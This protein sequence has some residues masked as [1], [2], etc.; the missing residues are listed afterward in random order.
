MR[1]ILFVGEIEYDKDGKAIRFIAIA[2][3]VTEDKRKEQEL[4]FRQKYRELV[5]ELTTNFL[6]ADQASLDRV[7]QHSLARLGRLEGTDRT[8]LIQWDRKKGLLQQTHE[9]CAPGIVSYLQQNRHIVLKEEMPWLRE[10]LESGKMIA[11]DRVA[12][13]PPEAER[14]KQHFQSHQ[15]ESLLLMPMQFEGET[16]GDLEFE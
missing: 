6:S 11:V 13:L 5:T 9:W 2:R 8:Y 3:D 7:I 10:K 12:D 1:E 4:I 14:E 16:I 15:I